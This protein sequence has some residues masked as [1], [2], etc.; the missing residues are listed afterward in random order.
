MGYLKIL[1]TGYI[2]PDNSGTQATASN[3]SYSGTAV[4]IKVAEFTPNLKRNISNQP[5]LA[6]NNTSEVNLGSL[7][8]MK[9]QLNCVLNTTSTTDMTTVYYLLDMVRTNGYK[10]MWYD[11]TEPTTEK[12]N[13]QLVY[14]IALNPVFGRQL[15]ANEMTKFNITTQFYRLAVVFN[16]IQPRQMGSSGLINY[17]L[18]G[19]VLP[20][21]TDTLT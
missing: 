10:I 21:L 4:T 3:M 7:E 16:D 15:S 8:N 20:V 2:K 11:Y 9:F 1:D 14:Q 6:T 18:S 13:G 5:D 17:T 12:N 19:V